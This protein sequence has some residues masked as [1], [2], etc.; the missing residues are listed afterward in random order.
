MII[1][2][3]GGGVANSLGLKVF[4]NGDWL[5]SNGNFASGLSIGPSCKLTTANYT[6]AE[7]GRTWLT[8]RWMGG[9]ASFFNQPIYLAPLWGLKIYIDVYNSNTQTNPYHASAISITPYTTN[10]Q[11]QNGNTTSISG[12]N[13]QGPQ[14]VIGTPQYFHCNN[15]SNYSTT[16]AITIDDSMV[17]GYISGSLAGTQ[18]IPDTG[19]YYGF[20]NIRIGA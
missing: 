6:Y 14:P 3:F 1:N 9:N 18:S 10:T 17:F 16:L 7:S 20:D 19:S 15:A 13:S 2:G 12:N 4:Q 11:W 8:P 5:F